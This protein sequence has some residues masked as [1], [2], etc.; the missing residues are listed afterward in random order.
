[1]ALVKAVEEANLDV[2]GGSGGTR[3]WRADTT[4]LA[5]KYHNMVLGGKGYHF[6]C[7]A[8]ATAAAANATAADAA[9]LRSNAATATLPLP[10]LPPLAT[11]AFDCCV[12]KPKLRAHF[13]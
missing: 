10:P 7:A 4:S 13:H 1:M 8:S 5:R 6:R 2:G 11:A 9:A 3:A 12:L